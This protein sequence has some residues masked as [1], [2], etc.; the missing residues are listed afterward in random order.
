MLE[1]IDGP[2]SNPKEMG[3]NWDEVYNK[4]KQDAFY[5]TQFKLVYPEGLTITNIKQAIVTFEESLLTPN[6]RF[7]QYLRGNDKAITEDELKGYSLFKQYGC[8]SCHQGVAVGGNLYQKFGDF[9]DYFVDRGNVTEADFGRFFVTKKES[10]KFVFK[11][12]GLRNV[13][14]TAPYLHDGSITSL[15]GAVTVMMKYQLGQIPKENDIQLIVQFLKTL[16][17]QYQGKD[18]KGT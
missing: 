15:E 11:V 9:G 1:Q 2:I 17:G 18:L 4:L 8:G 3:S 14:L 16:T 5:V 7:D 13:E 6:S 12:P 10:D